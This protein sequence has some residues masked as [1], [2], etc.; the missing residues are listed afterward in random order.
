MLKLQSASGA[1][2]AD[3][4]KLADN[5]FVKWFKKWFRNVPGL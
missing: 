1:A 3:C 2:A 4:E 5:K